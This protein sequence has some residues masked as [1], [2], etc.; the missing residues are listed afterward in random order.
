MF[1]KSKV[2]WSKSRKPATDGDKVQIGNYAGR[3][4]LEIFLRGAESNDMWVLDRDGNSMNA[5]DFD[6]VKKPQSW[7][8]AGIEVI[9]SI[10]WTGDN[11][12]FNVAKE[13]HESGDV[14]I[15]DPLT[16]KFIQVF[17]EA[18]DR[19]YVVDLAGDWREEVVV[20]SGLK[21][22]IYRNLDANRKPGRSSLW[23]T[24]LYRRLK[25]TWNYYSP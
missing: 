14:G 8:D 9:S 21:L 22:S 24:N 3:N 23:S 7:T 25:M 2:F 15:F 19:V 17:D 18:A 16:A 12:Q 5:Y 6:T 4:G 1:N 10:H 13:R 11:K 20:I